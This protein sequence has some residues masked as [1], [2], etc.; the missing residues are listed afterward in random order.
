MTIK[1]P[2]LMPDALVNV[3]A[4]AEGRSRLRELDS[5]Q[6]DILEFVASKCDIGSACCPARGAP[7]RHFLGQMRLEHALGV[8]QRDGA[9]KARL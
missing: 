4:A 8:G 7:D 1:S 2:A 6:R 9:G 3:F 5:F